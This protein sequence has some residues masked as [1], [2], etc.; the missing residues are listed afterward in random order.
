MPFGQKSDLKSGVVV[1]FDQ[2]YNEA[3][4]PTI[5]QCG[6]EARRGDDER[7]GAIIHNAMVA[8]LLPSEFVVADPTLTNANVFYELRVRHTAKPFTTVP[9][10][11]NVSTLSGYSIPLPA[12]RFLRG[13]NQ[14]CV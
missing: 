4:K 12:H 13:S 14:S 6:L 1:D 3:I 11:A 10:L 9:I 8:R 2:I 5:E 7:T